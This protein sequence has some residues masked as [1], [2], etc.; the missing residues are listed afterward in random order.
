MVGIL[1][2][3]IAILVGIVGAASWLVGKI[4]S[5]QENIKKLAMYQAGI[6]AAGMVV[7]LLTFADFLTGAGTKGAMWLVIILTALACT[8]VGLVLGYPILQGLFIDDLSEENRKKAEDFK[9][10]LAPFQVLGGIV[11]LGGGVYVL[12]F[13]FI[14]H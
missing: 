5:Q 11:A 13:K 12:L 10:A 1:F 14:L 6:G 3:L 7:G 2:P 4:P 9:N 8:L